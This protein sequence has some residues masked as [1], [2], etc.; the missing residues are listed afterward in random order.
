MDKLYSLS[1][2][3]MKELLDKKEVSSVEIT[4][5]VIDRIEKTDKDVCA[6]NSYNFENALKNAEAVDA[7]RAKGEAL[8]SLAGIPLAVKD[9][10][11]VKGLKTTC[12]SRMLENF[13]APFNAT[14]TDKLNASDAIIVGKT[15]MDEFA[16]GS[17][18]ESSKLAVAKNPWDTSRIPGGSSSGSAVTVAASQVPF[19]MGTDTGGS[20]RMPAAYTGVVG[21]KPTYG[22][23]SRYGIIP[24]AS[25]FDQAGP[26]ARNIDDL[27]M[28]FNAV[29]GRDAKDAVTKNY[30]FDGYGDSV[31]G[32]KIGVPK[33]YYGE[34]VQPAV[35]ERVYAA[36]ETLKAQGAE[37]IDISLPS[38]EYALAAYYIICCAEAASNLGRYDGLR[39]GFRGSNTSNVED[40]YLTTRSEGFGDEVKRR[41]MLGTCVLSSGYSDAYY[42]RAK[43]LQQNLAAEFTEAFKTC[44][45]IITPSIALTAWKFGE[46][47]GNPAEVYA[48]D[49]CTITLNIAG[50]PGMSVP[51]GFDSSNNMPV[52]FQIIGK[53][54]R[55]SDI[56]TVAKCYENAVGGFAVKE[57]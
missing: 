24:L 6:Y 33:E 45:V 4:K 18:G 37:I 35:K 8:G 12:S 43:L 17:S 48:A 39:Y 46:K 5:S 53:K 13:V 7:K 34:G 30:T 47:A 32:M 19:A 3:S 36:I 55:E 23:V 22:T 52:G 42:K 38:T 57:F 25:S 29:C 20:I 31:K 21:L 14:V 41:I 15:T 28:L 16:M 51:C 40:L 9:N 10:I 1:A 50:L 2:K 56:L 26:M 44:D 49:I 11:H 27:A 54:F